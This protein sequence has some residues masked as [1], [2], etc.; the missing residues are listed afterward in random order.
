MSNKIYV[1]VKVGPEWEIIIEA[2]LS[3]SAAN[4][5]CKELDR[6]LGTSGMDRLSGHEVIETKIIG[7]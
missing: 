2:H 7:A 4:A 3:E 1:I 5:R 6:G